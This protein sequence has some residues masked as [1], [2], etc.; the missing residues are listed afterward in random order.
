MVPSNQPQQSQAQSVGVG[1]LNRRTIRLEA[2]QDDAI[3]LS[4]RS[5][6]WGYSTIGPKE[7]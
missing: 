4:K 3:M 1:A 6:G 5:Y 2:S 7:C